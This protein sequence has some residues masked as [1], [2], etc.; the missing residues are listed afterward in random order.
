M[1]KRFKSLKR[2]LVLI[3]KTTDTGNFVEPPSGSALDEY[4][5]YR[6]ME[7]VLKYP[8]DTSSKQE[9]MIPVA[10]RPFGYT[11]AVDSA[12][13]AVRCSISQRTLTSGTPN[14]VKAKCN[15]LE[16]AAD[17]PTR[18]TMGFV[19]AKA[20]VK[21]S[22]ASSETPKSQ[23]TGLEYRKKNTASFTFPYG[24][25]STTTA[26]IEVRNEILGVVKGLGVGF[27]VGFN[28]EEY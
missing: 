11:S 2:A 10:V 8:R 16:A 20:T 27:S 4:V 19:P 22:T 14:G 13:E 6:K 24:Q 28:S 26:E 15:I 3:R 7:K 23:I 25:K 17:I 21:K 5:Q 1:A 18:K 9:A 12:A